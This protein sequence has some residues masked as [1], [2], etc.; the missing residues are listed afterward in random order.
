MNKKFSTLVAGILL[1]GSLPVAAQYC[2]TDGE[3]PY[4]SMSVASAALDKGFSDVKTIV[5]GYQYQLQVED[6]DGLVTVLTVE[7]DYSTGKLYLTSRKIE[8][9][10]LTH[11]LWEIK[12]SP[13]EINGR[14]FCFVNKETGYELTFDH[15]NSIQ[16]DKNGNFD[17]SW[18][19]GKNPNYNWTYDK[20]G[21]LDGCNKWWD[22]YTTDTQ[23][24]ALTYSRVYSY[25]HNADSIMYLAK[26][27]K[28]DNL[29]VRDYQK[30]PVMVTN[31]FQ[32]SDVIVT[33]KDSRAN[34]G[35]YAKYAAEA[36]RIKP[37]IAGAKVLN[38]EEINRM[39][40]ADGSYLTFNGHIRNYDGFEDLDNADVK[41]PTKFTIL[42]PKTKEALK[43][44]ENPMGVEFVAEESPYT[45]LRRDNYNAT[46]ENIGTAGTPNKYAGYDVLLREKAAKKIGGEEC[47]NYLMVSEKMYDGIETGNYTGL[48]VERQL[49]AHIDYNV[50]GPLDPNADPDLTDNKRVYTAKQNKTNDW[51]DPLEARYHWKVTYYPTQDSLVFEPFNASR[52]SEVEYAAGLPFEKTHLAKAYTPDYYNTVNEGKAYDSFYN[53]QR[54]YNNMYN[55]AAGVP[56]ALYAMNFSAVG[57][58][59]ALL[60]VSAAGGAVEAAQAKYA[61]VC[62][63]DE[64]QVSTSSLVQGT[65]KGLNN[66]A[67]VTNGK[68]ANV[69]GAEDYTAAMRLRVKFANGY[70]YL[71]RTS[72]P[73]GLYH[74]TLATAKVGNSTLT[75]KRANG[76]YLVD[77]MAGHLV[78][79]VLEAGQQDFTHMP[80]TQWVVE[81]LN[82]LEVNGINTNEAPVVK[83]SNREYGN[84]GFI[85]QLYD[86][87]DGKYYFI[88][89]DYARN[90]GQE[91]VSNFHL[92]ST[93]TCADTIKF[94]KIADNNLGYLNLTEDELRENVYQFEH[95][96]DMG[97]T[98]ALGTD[99]SNILKLMENSDGFELF[100]VA[101][102]VFVPQMT[103]YFDPNTGTE[104]QMIDTY[105]VDWRTYNAMPYW[106][107]FGLYSDQDGMHYLA[108]KLTA[109][110]Q[111]SIP[112]GVV[113]DAVP[114][115]LYKT[116]YKIKVK[117]ANLIDND[118]LFLAIDNQHKYQIAKESEITRANGLSFAVVELKENNCINGEHFYSLVNVPYYEC[119]AATAQ[120]LY[121]D[122]KWK[123]DDETGEAVY[124]NDDKG[125]IYRCVNVRNLTGKLAIE[126]VSRDAKIDD[127]CS[128]STDVFAVTNNNR[129][130]YATLAADY[131]NNLTKALA[132]RTIDEQGNE[133]L[134]E[135]S[136]SAKA[137]RWNMNYLGV[138]NRTENGNEG[139]Y[140]DFVA[141]SKGSRMPQY[142]FAVAADS[143]PAYR[144][145]NELLPSGQPKHG[146]NYSCQHDEEYAGYTEGRFLVNY[147]DSIK[148]ALIDKKTN[149]D[150]FKSDGY[151]RLGFKTA[152]HRGDSLFILNEGQNLNDYKVASEDPAENG[153]L[154]IIPTF[155]S[156]D[157][158]G[159]DKVWTAV[160]LDG[161]HNNVAF[162]LRN[163]DDAEGSVMIESNFAGVSKIGSFA[164]A[165]I[166]IINNVPVLAKYKNDN[167]NHNT[168][169]GTDSWKEDGDIV[170]SANNGEFINQGARFLFTAIDKNADATAN[171][172]VA[173]ADVTVIATQGA[174]IVKGA[175]G[176]V[177]TVANV[178]GQTIA[179]QVAASDNVTI[180]APAGIVVVS[181]DGEATKVVVK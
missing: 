116:Y 139:F 26:A 65:A 125:T 124:Y 64:S 114:T 91:E 78:Y 94:E 34:A 10:V 35:D 17:F 59:S 160:E 56:V 32:N 111:D 31:Q 168:G 16:K 28:I 1:A 20:K 70:T 54:E 122:L 63:W 81:Q 53:G 71:V 142:L 120:P 146:M 151:T 79:D 93:F 43:L 24:T 29:T 134:Y 82:C 153:R 30:K 167:G 166:K 102:P 19:N 49:Y 41:N 9:A 121:K 152:V 50:N 83:I 127:L 145:C 88:N 174:I 8:D 162:S 47:Y 148:K 52:M 110:L 21:L 169:D 143:V 175:A 57:D 171:E 149:A 141:A 156:K 140:V 163:T 98:L 42:N 138:E 101:A 136:H 84:E 130:V 76:S 44:A 178:L 61:A 123:F 11:S 25:F 23:A 144:W 161:T 112:Y 37:V 129:P 109:S 131:V 118:H 117:D 85:G 147:N 12:Q 107:Q 46:T 15:F 177:I 103:T 39:I 165:W 69:Q 135:D 22:L 106:M 96:Y 100:R 97:K 108:A 159:A 27:S 157:N 164:G 172:E 13:V 150:K 66:P 181:V 128:T 158:E 173:A 45:N 3:I 38:A 115:E 2:P 133:Y 40:D 67:Y 5:E 92:K 62:K 90:P 55:K 132:L 7:R 77:D 95:I 72:V 33:V 113:T 99:D 48:K 14:R 119:I 86:A 89:H 73:A 4:R 51:A 87:G 104:K 36:L 180:A 75:E 58:E 176:K 80:A 68:S 6:E 60:T 137:Q 74:I 154:Y 105:E 170:S 126:A 155:F 179:N 18:N